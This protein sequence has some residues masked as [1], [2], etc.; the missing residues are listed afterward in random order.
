MDSKAM[1]PDFL[2]QKDWQT[3]DIARD[4]SRDRPHGRTDRKFFTV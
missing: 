3:F 4:S 2:K 1:A